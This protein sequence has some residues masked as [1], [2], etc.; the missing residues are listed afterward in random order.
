MIEKYRKILATAALILGFVM[1]LNSAFAA[2]QKITEN[3]AKSSD[4]NSIEDPD[5]KLSIEQLRKKYPI[6]WFDKKYGQYPDC[7][8]TE[9][10]KPSLK[11]LVCGFTDDKTKIVDGVFP[12]IFLDVFK[13]FNEAQIKSIILHKDKKSYDDVRINKIITI[14]FKEISNQKNQ[15]LLKNR[16][17]NFIYH[18]K[19]MSSFKELP[20]E[21]LKEYLD[22]GNEYYDGMAL[23]YI[24]KRHHKPESRP[25]EKLANHWK[26]SQIELIN[27]CIPN[28][29][30]PTITYKLNQQN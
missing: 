19:V 24:I 15:S 25:N 14:I 3:T 2:E 11:N 7:E 28:K 30:I 1:Q 5:L 29:K 22:V 6:S 8:D 23:G 17:R 20:C 18:D 10:D 13:D 27:K 21:V 26:E 4:V 12:E 9:S 16:I